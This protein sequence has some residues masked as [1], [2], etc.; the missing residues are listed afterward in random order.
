MPRRNQVRKLTRGQ[1]VNHFP[2]C[3]ELG[4]KDNLWY[5]TV[6]NLRRNLWAIKKR[7]QE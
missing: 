3:W 2:G 6:L 4:R 1:K 5:I 7:F